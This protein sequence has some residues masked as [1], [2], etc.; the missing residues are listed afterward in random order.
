MRFEKIKNR[1]TISTYPCDPR[2]KQQGKSDIRRARKGTHKYNTRSKVNRV[3]TFKNTPQIFKK[4]T[5]DTLTTHI[6]SD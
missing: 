1:Y 2:E 6:G 5:I 3:T 4:D